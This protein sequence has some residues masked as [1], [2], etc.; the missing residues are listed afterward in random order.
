MFVIRHTGFKTGR[1]LNRRVHE[2]R[3]RPLRP[4]IWS[5]DIT[6]ALSFEFKGEVD[7]YVKYMREIVG[8]PVEAILTFGVEKP[9]L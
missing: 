5:D 7:D 8:F 9:C 4:S 2:D 3:M 6:K 1:F